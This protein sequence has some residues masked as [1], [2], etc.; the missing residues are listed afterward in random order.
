MAFV[1]WSTR[2]T[3]IKNSFN[4]WIF[5]SYQHQL[6]CVAFIDLCPFIA[7]RVSRVWS[8]SLQT[9]AF[10]RILSNRPTCWVW[11]PGQ[12][13]QSGLTKVR[14]HLVA[15]TAVC[16]AFH[17]WCE[18]LLYVLSSRQRRNSFS[19]RSVWLPDLSHQLQ[20]SGQPEVEWMFGQSYNRGQQPKF[21]SFIGNEELKTP[22]GQGQI[23]QEPSPFWKLFVEVY[24]MYVEHEDLV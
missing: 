20:V 8:S 16:E 2:S 12:P 22:F 21:H 18:H 10:P 19:K 9:W 14:L 23:I 3:A 5:W 6:Y 17:R 4:W 7:G 13:A 24:V 11:R 15:S 1:S